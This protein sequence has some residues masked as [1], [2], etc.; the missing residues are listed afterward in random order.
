MKTYYIL[1]GY[2]GSPAEHWFPW[3]KTELEKRGNKAV[4]LTLPNPDEPKL[5]EWLDSLQNAIKENGEGTVLGHSLGGVLAMRYVEAGG[6][7]QK[8]IL[9]AAPF[10]KI[11]AIP[12]IDNFLAKPFEISD[13]MRGQTQFTVI[14]SD[15]DHY[16][17][18]EHIKS[19]GE[20]LKVEP[21]IFHGYRH[22]GSGRT[23]FPE[24]LEYL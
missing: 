8:V 21:I 11:E 16:V 18:I 22:F 9:V 20:L 23:E 6:Q 19:W 24:I 15:D 10:K 3:L 7:P 5:N 1:H 4:V 13:I 14:G 2:Q 12:G 17:P